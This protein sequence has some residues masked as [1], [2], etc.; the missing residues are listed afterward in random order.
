MKNSSQ[1]AKKIKSFLGKMKKSGSGVKRIT[2]EEPVDAIV[3]AAVSE[4]LTLKKSKTAIRKLKNHFVDWNDLR[5]S[6][7]EEIVDVLGKNGEAEKKIAIGLPKILN[8]SFKKYNALTMVKLLEMNKRP[9]KA[10]LEKVEGMTGYISE[11][12]MLMVLDGHSIPLTEKMI[13][14]LKDNELVDSNADHADIEGFLLRQ[15]PASKGFDF[16]AFLRER[17]EETK[18]KTAKKSTKKT[19]KKTRK[20]K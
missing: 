17:S 3:D 10:E 6:R 19:V 5:V 8:A 1:Y 2:Y 9:A 15:V 20:K 14:Y 11:Y 12:M 4:Q 16:Y 13:S 18:K 7:Q